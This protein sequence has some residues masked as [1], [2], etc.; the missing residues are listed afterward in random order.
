VQ[1]KLRAQGMRNVYAY[2]YQLTGN[3]YDPVMTYNHFMIFV[4]LE[5]SAIPFGSAARATYQAIKRV[6][7]ASG[8][9][10]DMRAS[11]A[12]SWLCERCSPLASL[13][14]NRQK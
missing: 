5:G 8:L 6:R 10:F 3:G 13:R 9:G 14:S 7:V 12:R 11:V 1:V 2:G 4:F